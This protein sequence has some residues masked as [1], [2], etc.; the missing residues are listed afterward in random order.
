[1]LHWTDLGASKEKNMWFCNLPIPTVWTSS[2]E[3]KPCGFWGFILW[4]FDLFFCLEQ[5]M[6]FQSGFVALGGMMFP[7]DI[8]LKS[9]YDWC[10]V[11]RPWIKSAGLKGSKRGGKVPVPAKLGR[12]MGYYSLEP[13]ADKAV[14]HV[15]VGQSWVVARGRRGN[16]LLVELEL[17][18]SNERRPAWRICS[19][20]CY[21]QLSF[22]SHIWVIRATSTRKLCH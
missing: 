7:D 9:V 16:M 19:W 5:L 22:W 8:L 1:M 17:K 12:S 11:L 2:P 10:N 3:G 18:H 20:T 14:W 4:C 15:A 6:M 13:R 21:I